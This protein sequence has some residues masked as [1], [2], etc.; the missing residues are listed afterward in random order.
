MFF[1]QRPASYL[2]TYIKKLNM[3][4]LNPLTLE[5]INIFSLTYY[6]TICFILSEN[7]ATVPI[8]S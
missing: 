4:T 1:N 3:S 7:N 8:N 6:I 2:T 5:D